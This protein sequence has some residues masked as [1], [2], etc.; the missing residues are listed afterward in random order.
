MFSSRFS[1][2]RPEPPLFLINLSIFVKYFQFLVI[3]L[4]FVGQLVKKIKDISL[5][6]GVWFIDPSKLTN[7]TFCKKI[8]MSIII[9]LIND[10]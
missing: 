6:T 8:D 3:V 7:S 9:R 1:R 2:F 10:K 4:V 5:R